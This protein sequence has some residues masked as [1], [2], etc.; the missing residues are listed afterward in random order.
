MSI[1]PE[2]IAHPKRTTNVCSKYKCQKYQVKDD[3][4]WNEPLQ[5]V[6]GTP[7]KCL[8]A[9]FMVSC[10]ITLSSPPPPLIKQ[11]WLQ[12]AIP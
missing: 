9:C 3:S 2:I 8:V 7:I 10:L 1:R 11:Y 12:K 4:R 6:V 5:Y